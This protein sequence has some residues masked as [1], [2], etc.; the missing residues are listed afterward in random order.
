MSQV[1]DK[2]VLRPKGVTAEEVAAF[3]EGHN[4]LS[5]VVN[6]EAGYNTSAAEVYRQVPGQAATRTRMNYRPFLY[7]KDLKAQGVTLYGGDARRRSEA[8][9]KHK[10]QIKKLRTQDQNGQENLRLFNGYKYIVYSD[11]GNGQK[12]LQDFFQ[13]GGVSMRGRKKR[14][15]TFKFERPEAP[16][17]PDHPYT[18]LAGE[19]GCSLQYNHRTDRYEL[20]VT[21]KFVN[22]KSA[23][24]EQGDDEFFI[25][26]KAGS[27][28]LKLYQD[29]IFHY[30]AAEEMYVLSFLTEAEKPRKTRKRKDGTEYEVPTL[31]EDVDALEAELL[32]VPPADHPRILEWLAAITETAEGIDWSPQETENQVKLYIKEL[33]KAKQWTKEDTA[34]R[35]AV[36]SEWKR[37]TRK[38]TSTEKKL[39]AKREKMAATPSRKANPLDPRYTISTLHVAYNTGYSDL[40]YSVKPVEQFMIQHGIRLFKGMERYNEVHKLDFDLETTGLS[41]MRNRVFLA[42]IYD[43]RGN[44]EIIAPDEL[45]DD[46]SERRLIRAL[47]KRMGEIGPAIIK[48]Y[49][50]ENFDFQFLSEASTRLGMEDMF[51]P[52]LYGADVRVERR[53]GAT[54]KLGGEAEVYTQTVIRGTSVIDVYHAARRVQAVK[55]DME[56]ASLKY[57]CKFEDIAK[58]NRVY[59]DG[60]KI[61]PMWRDNQFYALRPSDNHYHRLS[62]EQQE[63]IRVQLQQHGQFPMGYLKGDYP[64]DALGKLE[65]AWAPDLEGELVL[66]TGR[67]LIRNYLLDDLYETNQVDERYN[68]DKFQM[69]KQIPTG[70]TRTST[71]GGSTVWNLFLTAWSYEHELAIPHP[72]VKYAFT[73]GLSRMFR[74]G[75]FGTV[76]KVDFSGLYPSTELTWGIFPPHDVLGFTPAAL[77][78]FKHTRDGFKAISGDETR[79][80]SERKAAEARSQPLKINNNSFFGSLGSS[81]LYWSYIEGAW[82]TTCRGRQYLRGMVKFFMRYGCVP[83]ILDTDG[84]NFEVPEMVM[85][86][87]HGHPLS[88]PVLLDTYQYTDAKG[89]LHEGFAAIVAKYNAEILAGQPYMKL[90]LEADWPSAINI[91]RKNYA[92]L[93]VGKKGKA[94]KIK[95][96]GNTIKDKNM[97]QYVREFVQEGIRLLLN[98]QGAEFVEYYYRHL[99]RIYTMQIPLR[100]IANKA[101]IK[102]TP[103]EYLNR[104]VNK[105]GQKKGQ[106]AHMELIIQNGVKVDLGDTVYFVSTGSRKQ[107][108]YVT[109]DVA[110]GRLLADLYTEAEMEANPDLTGEY[111]VERY[112]EVF[113]NK[114]KS[115]LVV[116]KPEIRETLLKTTPAERN[117]YPDEAM[118]LINYDNP[119][120]RDSLEKFFCLEESEVRFWNLSGLDP[121]ELFS[122]FTLPEGVDY[123]GYRYTQKLQQVREKFQP[124]GIPVRCYREDYRLGELVLGY[125]RVYYAVCPQS[126]EQKQIPPQLHPYLQQPVLSDGSAHIPLRKDYCQALEYY[127][128][129]FGPATQLVGLN[130]YPL[131]ELTTAGLVTHKVLVDPVAQG[132]LT[133]LTLDPVLG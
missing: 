95:F 20:H 6:I 18:P 32:D 70:F 83:T 31:Q 123:Y 38:N 1:T 110:T 109:R 17:F 16:A 79:P 119:D 102:Q 86:D 133:R 74:V 122:E 72:V 44:A 125:E 84:V 24:D 113:N 77:A 25:N 15:A 132:T 36:V 92:N 13:E 97:P 47:F 76:K 42:G 87:I 80:E 45:E 48:G 120:P 91:T 112:I 35:K 30:D 43:N 8:M 63:Q 118:E 58:P 78:Y 96:V 93:E 101:R 51:I 34:Q 65:Q 2:P 10:I 9:A 26:V 52:G 54:L 67:W 71:M 121:Y 49:N 14:Q 124:R 107:D 28:T 3:L 99:T 85:V 130:H 116:F 98:N 29:F 128:T 61:Y 88:E 5:H 111:N 64:V 82:E 23:F 106:Q 33:T 75:K 7:M 21:A 94:P 66:T 59:I 57:V 131:S 89:R 40:F 68:E 11:S 41:G 27:E 56:R 117:T 62:D 127:K 115:L 129:C 37:V 4:P 12:G 114:V 126:G 39:A 104:G 81:Y 105:N 53:E 73:G 46:E 60:D 103:Q 69:A 108:S 19:P 100:M 22:T 90:D 50:S 55:S